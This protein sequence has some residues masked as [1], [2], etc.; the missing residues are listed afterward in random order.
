MSVGIPS[1]FNFGYQLG[2]SMAPWQQ[3]QQPQVGWGQPPMAYAPAFGGSPMQQPQVGWGQPPLAYVPAFGG[4]PMQQPQ[5]GWGRPPMPMMAL[6]QPLQLPQ[7]P[8]HKLI[9]SRMVNLAL[10]SM[11]EQD[12]NNDNQ[13]SLTEALATS[14]ADED[15]IR[16]HFEFEDRNSDGQLSV[17]ERINSAIALQ[18]GMQPGALQG[19]TPEDRL[20]EL[21]DIL[22]AVENLDWL[23]EQI[24]ETLADEPF[25]TVIDGTEGPYEV[26]ENDVKG[27]YGRNAAN[28]TLTNNKLLDSTKTG[29]RYSDK[30]E[31]DDAVAFIRNYLGGAA[32]EMKHRDTNKDGKVSAD[33]M[34][35]RRIKQ[36]K[37]NL[38]DLD[39]DL[40][41]SVKANLEKESKAVF[42]VLDRNGDGNLDLK[43]HAAWNLA[44]DKNRDGLMSK[45]EKDAFYADVEAYLRNNRNDAVLEDLDAAA[46]WEHRLSRS[47]V[48]ELDRAI[49]LF[50]Q[51]KLTAQ[52]AASASQTN[53]A[54]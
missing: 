43:E 42:E 41:V 20:A 18:A 34:A 1:S 48:L 32:E 7:P 4:S 13:V 54:A 17:K 52:N 30:T 11:A 14:V 22:E 37:Q 25:T 45:A 26:A 28:N 46:N 9:D 3:Q 29:D 5:V 10:C 49:E 16:E 36:I 15:F 27:N 51:G 35:A 21:A 39:I 38:E 6:S 44:I 53:T 2:M 24:D 31:A 50:N 19:R 47:S 33:E 12:T 8:V 23:Q 40:P